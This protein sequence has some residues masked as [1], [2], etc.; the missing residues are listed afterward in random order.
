MLPP[1]RRPN[2]DAA[3]ATPTH[4]W[5]ETTLRFERRNALNGTTRASGCDKSVSPR[6][7]AINRS[8]IG[9]C[10]ISSKA[11]RTRPADPANATSFSRATGSMSSH[12]STSRRSDGPSSPSRYAMR[13]SSLRCCIV[14]APAH[15]AARFEMQLQRDAGARETAH[16]RSH[17]HLYDF[18]GLLVAEPINRHEQQRRSLIGRQPADCPPHFIESQPRL[19]APHRLIRPQPLFGDLAVLLANIS[20]ADLIYP[21]RL[22]DAKHPAVEPRALLKLMLPREGSLA[23]RLNQIV[24]V[25][26]GT[27]EPASK[28][29]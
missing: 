28:P 10:M 2:S 21:D 24:G 14:C 4:Q 20:C 18:R 25:G 22:H 16:D 15:P 12:P 13:S 27:G 5:R 26:R 8:G 1:R 17:R 23:R 3:T 11:R 29:A 7:A 19:D 6:A 9:S